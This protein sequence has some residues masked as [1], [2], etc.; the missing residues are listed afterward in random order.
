MDNK[1][2]LYK[3]FIASPSDTS[4]EREACDEV[5]NEINK[6]IGDKFKFR[7]ESVKWE[8]DAR[9]AFGKTPQD[10]INEQ[11]LND[12]RLFIG[13][14]FTKFGTPTD[15]Y[16]S[17]TEE[18]FY[19]AHDKFEK[20]QDIEIM[21]YFN[22]EA[23][24]P[25]DI[26]NTQAE[27][28]KEF[29]E[30]IPDKGGLYSQYK[31]ADDFKDKLRTH[32]IKFFSDRHGF[33]QDKNYLDIPALLKD[34]LNESLSA[35]SNQPNVWADPELFKEDKSKDAKTDDKIK[36]EVSDI[37]ENP[38]SVIIDAPPQF[39]LTCLSH[40]LIS[41]AWG[42]NS[43]W[44]YL[45]MKEISIHTEIDKI[46]AK[47]LKKLQLA[48][49][50]I[51]CIVLDSWKASLMGSMK[52]LRGICNTHKETPLIV[53]HTIG[54]FDFSSEEDVKINRE[55][56]KLTLSALPRNTIRKVVADYNA[57]KNIGDEDTVLS[58][59]VSDME[60]LNIHRTP[61]NCITLLKISEK[62]FD[63]SPVNRT[64]MI[65]M[66][67][68]VLF[69]LVE[70]PT[71]KNKPDVQD[72]EHVLG[73]FCEHIIR[74]DI[75][76]FSKDEF[77]D[78]IEAFCSEK[79]LELDIYTL[80]QI[81]DENH[82]IVNH[83]GKFRFKALYWIY[84]FSAKQMHIDKDFYQYIVSGERYIKFP[85]MIEFY[86]GI[87]RD[88][89]DMINI[90]INDLT[91][92]CDIVE[93]KTGLIG[94]INLLEGMEWNPSPEQITNIEKTINNEV[95]NSKLPDTLKDEYADKDY[96]FDKPY[97]QEISNI[98]QQYTFLILK[99]K[100][101]ASSRALRNSD[102]VNPELKKK[103][104]KEITRGWA[105]F[106]KILFLL[107]PIMAKNDYASFDGLGF[108]LCGSDDL[109]TDEKIARIILANPVYVVK[110]FKDDLFSP[111]S[112]PLLYEA[113]SSEKNKLIKHELIL[114]LIFSRPKEWEK[115]V[116]SYIKD[117]KKNSAY[118]LDILNLLHNRY[119]YDFASPSEAASMA[120]LLKM[121]HA[122]NKLA[123]NKLVD[124]MKQIPDKVIPKRDEKNYDQKI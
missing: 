38:Y 6:T 61:L 85:E 90:L 78:K 72:C 115:R 81:L 32:L 48:D 68:F 39:G 114:L 91:K 17:G 80:F 67:L 64:K 100:I 35:F 4:K 40:Y 95:K 103:L 123:S 94:D 47:E 22:D 3:C 25:S 79:F 110:S 74:N 88:S 89:D 24:S 118:L 62:H 73:Y 10:V 43:L 31:G 15:N 99:Q 98:F 28:V 55:F 120:N 29:K 13:I 26:D 33:E 34:R 106:S 124:S 58:K 49:K 65:E 12:I 27:R 21:F 70:L 7:I 66:F 104:L 52:V 93:Q 57:K 83:K 41:K 86:T 87:D 116:E 111:K 105:M 23:I 44:L 82:I 108:I 1:I 113:L 56:K 14:M 11:L 97:H 77:I 122:K 5:F 109:E 121:C 42:K 30:L 45:D 101:S 59:V 63:E 119:K 19:W 16:C 50:K 9:P 107:S 69:D 36:V 53:M 37:I 76:E 112:A 46:I 8:K 117:I 71:Y 102:Y 54:D 18:E 75:Y 2:E 84:Y 20:K 51:D 92:Q 60:V 96:S